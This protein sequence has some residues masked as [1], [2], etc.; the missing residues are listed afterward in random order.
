M[1]GRDGLLV[2]IALAGCMLGAGCASTGVLQA[3]TAKEIG[4][5][6]DEIRITEKVKLYDELKWRASH[7]EQ[8]YRCESVCADEKCT[9]LDEASTVCQDLTFEE[10]D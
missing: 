6:A 9:E 3:T 7:G 5:P 2:G 4:A 10:I 8:T 1:N